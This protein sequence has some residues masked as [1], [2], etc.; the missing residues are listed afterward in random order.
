MI[1]NYRSYVYKK[2]VDWSLLNEGFTIPVT[3]QLVFKDKLKSLVKRGSS[4]AIKLL[5]DDNIYD[6]ELKNQAFDEE[7]FKNHPDIV[8][9]RYSKNSAISNKLKS[10]FSDTYNYLQNYRNSPEYIKKKQILIPEEKRE[11]LVVY[12]TDIE[13][14]F[15][16]ECATAMD[17]ERE[18]IQI[19]SSLEEEMEF[20]LNYKEIDIS[21]R[22]DEMLVNTKIRRLNKAIGENLKELYHYNC[23]I[24]N[25]NFSL[26][27]G[28]NIAEA[29]H[30]E[31]FTKSLNNDAGNIIIL[32]PNHHS[33]IHRVNPVFNREKVMFEYGNGFKEKVRLN[34]HLK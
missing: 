28:C 25:E 15:Y 10:I 3:Y 6:A 26:N 12:T 7:K 32:C 23:Q 8:Q 2:D 16:V 1:Q 14:I 9:V 17:I 4:T 33:V 13:N 11:F 24:C 34:S 5:I 27:Y 18:K 29:H 31:Y 21:A 19:K 22:I 30:I 20:N